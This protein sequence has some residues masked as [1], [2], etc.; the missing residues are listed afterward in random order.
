MRASKIDTVDGRRTFA[1][2]F[3][4]ALESGGPKVHAHVVVGKADGTAHGGHLLQGHVRP[5]LEVIL[6][7]VPERLRR[8]F[9]PHIG[10]ALLHPGA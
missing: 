6:V 7:E 4:V 2:I 9:Y 5:T 8:T 10:L 1:V 3:D